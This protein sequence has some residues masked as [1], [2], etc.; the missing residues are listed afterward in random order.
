MYLDQRQRRFHKLRNSLHSLVLIG[1]LAA[2]M[3]LCAALLWGGAGVVAALAVMA[4]FLIVVPSVPG[5]FVLS[6]YRGRPIVRAEAPE[7]IALVELLAERAEL[8]VVPRLF[9]VPSAALN[10]LMPSR[11][12]A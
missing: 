12:K 2:I 1:G 7:L 3:V 6:L 11:P 4:L 10:A 5:E 8:P 9:Y